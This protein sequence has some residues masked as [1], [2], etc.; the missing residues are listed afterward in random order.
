M[1]S[2]LT[3]YSRTILLEGVDFEGQ[4]KIS[5]SKVLIVGAGG[6]S[7][8]IISILAC[9]GI[10]VIYI[11]EPD[12]LELSN[13]Q[14]QFIYKNSDIGK[15]KAQ[16]AKKFIKELNPEI[17][18][19]TIND[20]T[21]ATDINAIVNGTDNFKSRLE[22][23]KL[24]FDLNIPFF[25]GSA[26][27]FVGHVYSFFP[28]MNFGCYACLFGSDENYNEKLTCGNS[29]VFPSLPTIIGSMMAHN[30][31]F[32]LSY[33]KIELKEFFT[34]FILVDF[35]KQ[36]YFK[37]ITFEKDKKCTICQK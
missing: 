18:V 11:S 4:K 9:S 21:K 30:V 7:S 37:E 33:H 8:S 6:L 12:T 35:L 16:L 3:R 2:F 19:I 31:L 25:T 28:S 22:C 1:Q 14:R 32:F 24:A 27:N 36:K 17:E 20:I 5:S 10:G 23:N 13:L 15:S 29:G 26:V 34:K